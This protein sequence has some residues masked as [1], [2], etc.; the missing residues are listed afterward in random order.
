[1]TDWGSGEA[2]CNNKNLDLEDHNSATVFI[3]VKNYQSCLWV[4][5]KSGIMMKY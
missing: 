1:M 5:G 2:Y 4:L 3:K